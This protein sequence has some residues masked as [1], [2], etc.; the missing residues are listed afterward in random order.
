MSDVFISYSRKDIA[1]ARLIQ[2][3]LQQSQIDTWIDWER[4]PVGERWWNEICQAIENAN[5]FMFIISKNSIGSSVCKDEIAHALK[6]NKRIIPIIV[7]NLK[8]EAIKEFA[9]DLPQFNWIIFERDHLFRIEENPEVRSDKPEDSQVALPKLPQFE[10]ALG[11]LSK[12]IHTDWEW[13]KYHTR[14]QVNALL[15]ENNQRNPSYLVRGTALEESEKQLLQATGKDPQPTVLQVEYVTASRKEETLR[16]NEKLRLEQKARQRQRLVIWAVGIGLALAMVLGGVAWGQRNQYLGETHVRATAQNVAEEQRNL[17]A[18]SQSVAEEQSNVRATAQVVAEE[19]RNAAATAQAVAEEQRKVAV[20]QSNIALS[21]QLAAQAINQIEKKDISLGLLLSIEAYYHAETMDARSSLLRLIQTEPLL[22]FYING[23]TDKVS[24]VAISPDGKT[25]ASA[26]EDTTI[27][28]WDLATGNPVHPALLG[29]TK[30]VMTVAFSPD[31]RHLASGAEDG[32]VLLWNVA[33]GYS[34]QALFAKNAWVYALAF[35]PDGK[36]LAA[37]FTDKSVVLWSMIDRSITCPSINGLS[38]SQEFTVLAFSPDGKNLAVGNDYHDNGELTFWNPATCQQNG[39]AIDTGR[40]TKNS[41]PTSMKEVTSM[42][43]SPDGKQLAIGEV[44]YLLVLDATTRQPLREPAVIHTNY[45]VQSIAYSPDSRTM[46]LGMADKSIVLIDSATGQSIGQPLFGQRSAIYSVAFSSD[47]HSLVSGG[48]DASVLVWDLQNQPLSRT[49][50]GHTAAVLSVVF[51]PDGKRLA[52][53]DGDQ[54]IR[55]W[56][57]TTWQTFGQPLTVINGGVEAMAFSPDSHILASGGKDQL[58]HLWDVSTGKPLGDPLSGQKDEIQCL[59]FSPDGKWLAAGGKNN[60]LTI[61][62]MATRTLYRDLQFSSPIPTDSLSIDIDKTIRSVGFSPDS[63]T[64][65]FSMGAG[66]TRFIDMAGL[67][68]G[69]DSVRQLN[70]TQLSA[71][72]YIL[73]KMSSDGKLVALAN[74]MD[75]RLYDA[76]SLQMVGLPMYGHTDLVTGLVFTPD[77]SLLAS[78]SQD[79]TV[80]LWDAATAQSVGLPLTGHSKWISSLDISPDGKWLASASADQTVRIWDISI[81][82]WQS[83]ACQL[84]RRNLTGPEWQQF[85]PDEPYH[86]TCPDQPFTSDV[87]SQITALARTRLEKGQGEEAKA[88]IQEG[89]DWILPLGVA[90][91]DNGLCWFGSLD[92]FAAEVLPACERAVSLA[93]ASQVAGFRDSRGFALALT[94]QTDKAI[95]DFQ[96]FVDWSKQNGYYDTDGRQ[97]EEWIAALKRGE[98]P[99]DKQLLNSLRNP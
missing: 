21:R 14:L 82:D 24:S 20:E 13:V 40:L 52:S 9:P 36:Y 85:L 22:R 16:Q 39:E 30:G 48:W 58:I 4:I 47:G 7:D 32:Q 26:S 94:G 6:N 37:S 83:L 50:T 98:N 43:Y 76:I 5:V 91:A 46:A 55:L 73:A 88:I 1:F 90:V 15:W 99:F 93:P 72:N 27:G 62:E 41:D 77:G 86:L 11:R 87:I 70:W 10:E 96:A 89:L 66:I 60:H 61:W 56:D 97:R 53:A 12:A 29:H 80:R 42:A 38:E 28:L 71:T 92:G 79:A 35:S 33:Q 2:E 81:Q 54:T 34:Y 63:A 75:I 3:S 84:V 69:N 59:A 65:Y 25:I 67:E 57:T 64:L 51:S 31:G 19:Q 45:R 18:T 95:E 49:L 8:P 78:S 74:T 68:S 44:D 17:A 23:H